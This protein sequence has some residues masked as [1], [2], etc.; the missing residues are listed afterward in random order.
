M[1][2]WFIGLIVGVGL[3]YIVMFNRQNFL[4]LTTVGAIGFLTAAAGIVAQAPYASQTDVPEKQVDQGSPGN[5]QESSKKSGNFPPVIYIIV[6]AYG[7]SDEILRQTNYDNSD[8]LQKLGTL[9]FRTL[10]KSISNYFFS[11][12]SISNTLSMRYLMG[13]GKNEVETY[14]DIRPILVGSNDAARRFK[15]LGYRMVT[16]GTR[17]CSD[18]EHT[19][20]AKSTSISHETW[21]FLHTTPFPL[22]LSYF[23]P[24]L[25][26]NLSTGGQY[27][28]ENLIEKVDGFSFSK[29][30]LLVHEL[31]VH[32]NLYNADCSLQRKLAE[33]NLK[34]ENRP[35][36]QLSEKEPFIQTVKC[37]NKLLVQFVE[38]I[39]RKNK[40][41]IIVV[42][43]DHG[44]GFSRD[45]GERSAAVV[46]ERSAVLS[47][48]RL[49]PHCDSL[50]YDGISN[51]NHFRV[52]FAC[53][54]GEEP[55]FLE[56]KVSTPV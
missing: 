42:T 37:I 56:D 16:S 32:D 24:T 28:I 44:T 39:I 8:F 18:Y 15:D 4:L 46:R 33:N 5:K 51:V 43:A 45:F 49:P 55:Q 38:M 1:G 7:R 41:A 21:A 23:S 34:R 3:T 11:N 47:S 10:K 25:Y 27:R 22:L 19:C 6:D 52:I 9:G 29:L 54:T 50:L 12:L 35:D 20:I 26:G 13:V 31:G 53:L 17:L 40:D 48:W 30:F 36:R 2:A 14:A